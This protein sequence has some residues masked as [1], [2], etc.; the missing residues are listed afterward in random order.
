MRGWPL[1]KGFKK[2]Y[3]KRIRIFGLYAQGIKLKKNSNVKMRN[4]DRELMFMLV[5]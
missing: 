1:L 4:L 2:N 5:E 3:K